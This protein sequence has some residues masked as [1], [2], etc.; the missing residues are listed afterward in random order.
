MARADRKRLC[1]NLLAI[2]TFPRWDRLG[3]KACTAY[4]RICHW[5][6]G[7]KKRQQEAKLFPIFVQY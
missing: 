1:K 4:E 5:I 6:E 2:E 7:M 3:Q